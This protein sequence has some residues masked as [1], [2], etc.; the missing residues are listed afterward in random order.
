MVKVNLPRIEDIEDERVLSIDL[1]PSENRLAVAT[2]VEEKGHSKPAF[3][4]ARKITRKIDRLQKEIDNLASQ[5]PKS[6]AQG[7][8]LPEI[9]K[10][11]SESDFW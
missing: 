7:I 5:N 1:S 4:K 2:I 11:F 9:G 8:F 10:G 6:K 3:F